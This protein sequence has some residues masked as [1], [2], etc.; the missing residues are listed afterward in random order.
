MALAS[1]FSI[2][3]LSRGGAG[4]KGYVKVNRDVAMLRLYGRFFSCGPEFTIELTNGRLAAAL[5]RN[6]AACESDGPCCYGL[7]V[8]LGCAAGRSGR[9]PGAA[10][11]SSSDGGGGGS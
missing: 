8:G 4:G 9:S 7:G 2:N 6:A 1:L 3:L 10:L 5:R 11:S